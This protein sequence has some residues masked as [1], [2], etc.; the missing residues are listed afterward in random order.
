MGKKNKKQTSP[1]GKNAEITQQKGGSAI[2]KGGKDKPKSPVV[3]KYQKNNKKI[4]N[5]QSPLKNN[6]NTDLPNKV[7]E[8][9]LKE[10][11]TNIAGKNKKKRNKKN[12]RAANGANAP[13]SKKEVPVKAEKAAA[14]PAVNAENGE[15]DSVEKITDISKRIK[16]RC[17]SKIRKEIALKGKSK[18]GLADPKLVAK[19]LGKLKNKAEPHSLAAQRN[20]VMLEKLLKRLQKAE[21]KQ[22]KGPKDPED[23]SVAKGESEDDESLVDDDED[24]EQD[25][26]DAAEGAKKPTK[27]AKKVIAAKQNGKTDDAKKGKPKD[28]KFFLFIGNLPVDITDD[29]ITEHFKS[30][31][32]L[33]KVKIP[34]PRRK[35]AKR[36]AYVQFADEPSRQ[37]ALELHGSLMGEKK[38][39]VLFADKSKGKCGLMS[40]NAKLNAKRKLALVT[41]VAKT[42]VTK[43]GAKP[44]KNKNKKVNMKPKV[45]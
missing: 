7:D 12:K 11:A 42:G 35:K 36:F 41:E 18:L 9:K 10:A 20:I 31:G 23:A 25:S 1:N 4:A 44:K 19:K 6:K 26:E 24:M 39:T 43:T 32:T 17:K 38:I 21:K 45:K 28:D 16:N 33:Q 30:A 29:M 22:H 8:A 13:A 2:V 15:G 34:I 3:A 5:P 14:K 27:P 37:K 40:K